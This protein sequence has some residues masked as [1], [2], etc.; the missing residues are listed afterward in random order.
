[1]PTACNPAAARPAAMP[2]PPALPRP[3]LVP[4]GPAAR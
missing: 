1:M 4:I 3:A 2:V